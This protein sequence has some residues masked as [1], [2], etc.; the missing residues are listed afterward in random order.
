MGVKNLGIVFGPTLMG[1]P[2]I[3]N[4]TASTIPM[5]GMASIVVDNGGLDDMSW[6]CRVVETILENY[7]VI[8]VHD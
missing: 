6:Q 4:P 5:Q 2:A 3:P 7:K 8:F 1:S